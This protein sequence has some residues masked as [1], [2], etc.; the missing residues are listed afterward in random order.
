[1]FIHM[2][3]RKFIKGNTQS[4]TMDQVNCF[5]FLFFFKDN[6]WQMSVVS[7]KHESRVIKC[8]H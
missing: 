6:V 3:E 2:E 1:M 4:D 5:F 7:D 8:H